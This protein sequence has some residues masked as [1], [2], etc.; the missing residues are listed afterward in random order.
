MCAKI[1]RLSGLKGETYS[2]GDL[3]MEWQRHRDTGQRAAQKETHDQKRR[4]DKKGNKET[5]EEKEIE[6]QSMR[7]TDLETEE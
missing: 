4:G 3:D 7:D 2:E 5:Q 6:K 1:H